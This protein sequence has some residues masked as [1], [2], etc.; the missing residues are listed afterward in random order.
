MA[1][2]KAGPWIAGTVAAS[3]TV[4]LAG[5]FL[6]IS[7]VFAAAS[8]TRV[9]AESQVDQN[10]LTE[11]RIVRLKE[12]FEQLDALRAELASARLQIPT[13]YDL[14]AYQ[15]ELSTLAVTHGVTITSLQTGLAEPVVPVG[16]A[17]PVAEAPVTEDAAATDPA[18]APAADGSTTAAA[19]TGPAPVDSFYAVNAS[20]NVVGTHQSVL[21]F[22]DALQRGAQRLLLVE[23]LSGTALGTAE[24]SSGRPATNPGDL[25]LTITGYLYVLPE[26]SVAPTVTDPA[27]APPAP[28]A[29]PV[30]DPAK[31][32]FAPLG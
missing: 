24:S 13:S 15:R 9:Q 22:L 26:T 17:A 32:P 27:A 14:A 25:E 11:T 3:L 29:L 20:L 4:G 1:A 21:A 2:P 30:P 5:W 19:P 23:G 10:A 12:Q 18:A 7:P 8:E 31:N 16:A 28:P 6:V